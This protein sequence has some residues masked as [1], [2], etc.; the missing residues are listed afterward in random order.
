MPKTIFISCGQYA[1]AE[2]QLGKQISELVSTITDCV[3]FFAEQVQDLN[4]LD[5]NILSALRDCV[6]FITVM[7]PRGE[8]ER[9]DG[10]VLVRASVWI[11]QEIAIATYISRFEHRQLPIIAFKHRLVSREGIRDLLHLNPVEFTNEAEVLAELPHRLA[12]WK[13][14]KLPEQLAPPAP[15]APKPRAN[16]CVEAI[17]VGKISLEGDI[18]T[19]KPNTRSRLI[20]S[21]AL[22]ADISN[23]P[24][25]DTYTAKA[26]IRAAIRIDFGGRQRTYSPLP[27]L[28]E[29]TNTVYLETGGRKT[30]VLAVGEDS[31][32]GAWKFV[33]NHRSDHAA[34]GVSA[35]DGTNECPIP[36]DIP[37]EILMID[38]NSGALL[39]K[40]EYL[41]TFDATNNWPFLKTVD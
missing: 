27:W 19:L 12:L 30:V 24:T 28:E 7:H 29:Y 17:K 33:L 41:W 21:R 38:M 20:P 3:P 8:I 16:L 34:S 40:F 14:L 1:P 32:I 36:S 25:D 9:P 10:S 2:K 26:A 31:Q 18:W 4:G 37:F 5:A 39:S 6:G 13:S 11:E 15:A 22:L 23:V 35:M